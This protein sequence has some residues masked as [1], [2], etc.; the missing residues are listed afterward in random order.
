MEQFENITIQNFETRIPNN[1]QKYFDSLK[2]EE[3][4][5]YLSL[6]IT[7]S[8][9]LYKYLLEKLNLKK[10]DDMIIN[11]DNHFQIVNVKNMDIYQYLSIKYLKYIYIRNNLYIERLT[12]EEMEYLKL[13]NK[14]HDLE[15]DNDAKNFI[16][17][18]YLK[19][20]SEQIDSKVVNI[21]Y[22]PD[23]LRFYKPNNALI[24]AIRFDDYYKEPNETS[25]KWEAK[26]NDKLL[27]LDMIKFCLISNLKKSDIKSEVI[28]YN[29]FSVKKLFKIDEEKKNSKY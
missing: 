25:E 5:D 13:K 11:A 4:K 12:N 14:N 7:Y 18:T 19:V 6:Y 28:K 24:I 27:E 23:N 8:D 1:N 29:D 26:Y 3:K 16:S 9:L 10:Y 15:L 2:E 21:N 20:I 22:G 17:N